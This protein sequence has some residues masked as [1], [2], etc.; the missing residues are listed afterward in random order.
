M[1]LASPDII[2]RHPMKIFIASSNELEYERTFL[3]GG[4]SWPLNGLLY[5]MGYA[6]RVEPEKW[7]YLDSSMGVDHKQEE[8]N[9]ALSAC[10]GVVVLFWRKFGEYTESEFLTALRSART[11]GAVRRLAVLFKETG[12]TPSLE[13]DAFKRN[14][15]AL[16]GVEPDFFSSTDELRALFLSFVF[17]LFR[18]DHPGSAVPDTAALVKFG[19]A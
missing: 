7:E 3:T 19:L 6:D 4:V 15:A 16:Y 12:E 11:G 13:L 2:E 8:Y 5:H 9:R 10:D 1:P 18:D 17:D 14:C